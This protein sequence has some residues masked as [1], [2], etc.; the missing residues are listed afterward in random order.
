MFTLTAFMNPISISSLSLVSS[1]V[2]FACSLH[3]RVAARIRAATINRSE[4]KSAE[5][6]YDSKAGVCEG[7][8]GFATV[9]RRHKVNVDE[10]C[11]TC[12]VRE[13]HTNARLHPR[14]ARVAH[15]NARFRT[16]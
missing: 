2:S 1:C 16:G 15:M 9:V 5:E 6:F 10:K 4:T 11:L 8:H 7:R 12:G 14:L 13:S 3:C